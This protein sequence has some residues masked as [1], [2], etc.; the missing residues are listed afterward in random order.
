MTKAAIPTMLLYLVNST[1]SVVIPLIAGGATLVFLVVT[2]AVVFWLVRRK[3][4]RDGLAWAAA[5]QQLG[6]QLAAPTNRMA[7][8]LDQWRGRTAADLAAAGTLAVQPM[9]G[10]IAGRDVEARIGQE[11]RRQRHIS[12][13]SR[14]RTPRYFTI[15]QARWDGPAGLEFRLANRRVGS[16]IADLLGISDSISIGD[17]AFDGQF[18]LRANDPQRVARLLYAP[19]T[20]GGSV[21]SAFLG[22]AAQGW[23]LAVTDNAVLIRYEGKVLE[24][25]Q[26]AAGLNLVADLAGKIQYGANTSRI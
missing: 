17:P 11:K 25:H 4:R 13:Y 15:C 3:D 6:F 7:S 10:Q 23:N 16:W 8:D 2:L 1:D 9:F 5:A 21:L 19:T 18:V 26:L 14:V 22:A 12:K 20:H 24:A